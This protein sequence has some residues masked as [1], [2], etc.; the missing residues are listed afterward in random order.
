MQEVED[1]PLPALK[2][3]MRWHELHAAAPYAVASRLWMRTFEFFFSKTLNGQ[4]RAYSAMEA[5]CAD[6]GPARWVRR[7]GR[8]G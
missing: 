6:D 4:K 8:T 7:W 5:V 2:S 3:Y 1:E